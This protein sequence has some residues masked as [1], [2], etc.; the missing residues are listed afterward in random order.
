MNIR[1]SHFISK[2]LVNKGEKKQKINNSL[3]A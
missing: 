3:K 2:F 1:F